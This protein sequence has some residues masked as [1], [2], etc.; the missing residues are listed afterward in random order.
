MTAPSLLPASTARLVAAIFL[1]AML[2]CARAFLEVTVPPSYCTTLD[3]TP[4]SIHCA[5]P[6]RFGWAIANAPVAYP[7]VLAQAG[8]TGRVTASLWASTLG[9]VDSA[10]ITSSTNAQFTAAVEAVARTWRFRR[11]A[12]SLPPQQRL[13]PVDILF[14]PGGCPD[15]KRLRQRVVALH[16]GLLI[17]VLGCGT[18]QRRSVSFVF[19]LVDP[20]GVVVRRVSTPPHT[21]LVGFGRSHIYLVRLDADAQQFLERYKAIPQ[22]MP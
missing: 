20:R 13:L 5:E 19:D 10:T 3:R 14:K 9:N 18:V 15:P 22:G 8:V 21:E 2:A 11:V 4:T 1:A 7:P 16:T 12:A 6:S 17:E